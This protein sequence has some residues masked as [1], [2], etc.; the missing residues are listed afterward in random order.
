M[1]YYSTM[2]AHNGTFLLQRNSLGAVEC[3]TSGNEHTSALM[4]PLGMTGLKDKTAPRTAQNV[5]HTKKQN[6]SA[7]SSEGDYSHPHLNCF[8]DNYARLNHK[9]A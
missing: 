8:S 3:C 2:L 9:T 6:P 4:R 1:D 7:S 5:K